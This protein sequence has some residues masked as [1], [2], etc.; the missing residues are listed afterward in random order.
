MVNGKLDHVGIAV[1]DF[2]A[3]AA[4]YARLGLAVAYKDAFEDRGL[5][6]GYLSDGH[7]QLELLQPLRSDTPL[8]QFLAGRGEGLHHLCF[9][10][11]DLSSALADLAA[12]GY[13]PIPGSPWRGSRGTNAYLRP[14]ASGGVVLELI[15][16]YR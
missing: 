15:E 10:V 11:D 9:E 5:V 8:G 7:S 16:K 2:D 13:E 1:R 3:T 14:P 6:R 12:E 4:L